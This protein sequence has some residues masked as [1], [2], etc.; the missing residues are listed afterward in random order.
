[1]YVNGSYMLKSAIF[2]VVC[3]ANDYVS[4]AA[5][6]RARQESLANG[7]LTWKQALSTMMLMAICAVTRL[8]LKKSVIARH[9]CLRVQRGQLWFLQ[10]RSKTEDHSG[11]A[12]DQSRKHCNT[13]IEMRFADEWDSGRSEADKHHHERLCYRKPR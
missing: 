9:R 3:H 11:E 10:R 7:I 1:M 4:G 5:D 6:M 8:R 2:Y 13:Q 12:R